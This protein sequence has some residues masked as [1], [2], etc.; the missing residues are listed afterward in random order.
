M[1]QFKNNVLSRQSGVAILLLQ[2]KCHKIQKIP[3]K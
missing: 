1:R 2:S 3:T